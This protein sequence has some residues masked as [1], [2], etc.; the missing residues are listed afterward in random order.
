MASKYWPAL[1]GLRGA[2]IIT[3]LV[4]HLSSAYSGGFIGVNLFFVLSG[5]LI[6]GKLLNEWQE[7]GTLSFKAFYLSRV[8]RLMP[9]LLVML[10][11][12]GVLWHFL[13]PRLSFIK[14]IIPVLFYYGNWTGVRF[15][16]PLAP[17]W[18]L[19]IEE[20]FY[21]VW[22][23]LF[24]GLL[25]LVPN[26]RSVARLT[27]ILAACL[28][29]MRGLLFYAESPLAAY[30][31]TLA[32]ADSILMGSAFALLNGES[33][34]DFW[35]GGRGTL[36]G[37]ACAGTLIVLSFFITADSDFLGLGGFTIISGYSVA[38]I[39][40][41]LHAPGGFLGSILTVQW[42]VEI[43]KRSYGIY[44]YHMPVFLALDHFFGKKLAFGTSVAL[45]VL[46]TLGVSML[47][48]RFVELPFLRKKVFL[49]KEPAA[50]QACDP[51]PS[52]LQKS[53]VR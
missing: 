26:V 36:I 24:S 27:L 30:D 51:L 18:S 41:S 50:E 47:S 1:D 45:K 11:L 37:L 29:L 33:Q 40:H 39:L 28:A 52:H 12:S 44:L 31:S 8:R 21:L 49:G 15:A 19:C 23:V 6:T 10:L 17:T 14:A 3:V 32:C 43:G 4:S 38:I 16:G 48:Y 35:K 53:A 25:L 22:P 13:V 42:L 5:F 46:V 2:C 20:Q 9:A 7:T 34:R